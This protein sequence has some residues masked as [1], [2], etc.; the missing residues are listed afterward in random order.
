MDLV[1]EA[2]ARLLAAG[3]PRDDRLGSLRLLGVLLTV[4]GPTGVVRR[5]L[6]QLAAEFGL[7]PDDSERWLTQLSAAGAVRIEDDAV[8]LAG[9]DDG[10]GTG[11]RLDEFLSVVADL[12]ERR[13]RRRGLARPVGAAVTAVAAAVAGLA[14]LPAALDEPT[15]PVLTDRTELSV[16]PT[17]GADGVPGADEELDGS[18]T[19]GQP[20]DGAEV[21]VS[22]PAGPAPAGP[23]PTGAG[24]P[25][26][27]TAPPP[28]P[29]GGPTTCPTVIGLDRVPSTVPAPDDPV[30]CLAP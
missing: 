8:V 26:P 21:P 6:R 15:S 23:A 5:D 24:D 19:P 13:R 1:G 28:P 10:A 18:E 20:A 2:S 29:D 12:D 7:P 25:A 9:R 11:L 4:A 16:P 14:L 17:P 30:P 27:P 22:A 3:F